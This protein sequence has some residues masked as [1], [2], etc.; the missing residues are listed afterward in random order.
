[1]LPV[2]FSVNISVPWV[3]VNATWDARPW[4][5]PEFIALQDQ[6]FATQVAAE[7][8]WAVEFPELAA[9]LDPIEILNPITRG[10]VLDYLGPWAVPPSDAPLDAWLLDA[11]QTINNDVGINAG[12]QTQAH[13]VLR[14][15]FALETRRRAVQ[16]ALLPKFEA[17]R[18]WST[19]YTAKQFCNHA[20]N[21][22][23][24]LIE[25]A[26]RN[27]RPR[28]TLL[29]GDAISS[30]AWVGCCTDGLDAEDVVLRYRD[31]REFIDA[32]RVVP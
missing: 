12:L 8:A 28:R 32:A 18:V 11:A 21:K 19:D 2:G 27:D 29:L 25:V 22:P 14:H 10:R 3:D 9:M 15:R 30:G 5:D 7:A 4:H 13:A 26:A 31:L 6:A 24:V 1:M 20:A 23:G 17:L 16:P